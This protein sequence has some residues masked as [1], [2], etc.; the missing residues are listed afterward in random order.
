MPPTP[1]PLT[2]D[3]YAMRT[4][5]RNGHDIPGKMVTQLFQ[6]FDALAADL[7]RVTGERDEFNRLL[8]DAHYRIDA[9][10]RSIKSAISQLENAAEVDRGDFYHSN[11]TSS[12]VVEEV[13]AELRGAFAQ[14]GDK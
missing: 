13:V 3:D 1:E 7:A 14:Y 9:F 5:A 8:S 4:N 10:V 12:M 11:C 2:K 6:R